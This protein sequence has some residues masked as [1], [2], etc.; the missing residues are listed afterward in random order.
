[1]G[2]FQFGLIGDFVLLTNHFDEADR[3]GEGCGGSFYDLRQPDYG[4]MFLNRDD[5]GIHG[6]AQYIFLR[7]R[8]SLLLLLLFL[9][10]FFLLFFLLFLLRFLF[11]GFEWRGVVVSLDGDDPFEDGFL[12]VGDHFGIFVVVVFI[13]GYGVVEFDFEWSCLI[14]FFCEFNGDFFL[15][16]RADEFVG[17]LH[18]DDCFLVGFDLGGGWGTLKT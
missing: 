13:G 9:F 6:F 8:F 17:E 12:G 11:L 18:G 7:A 15:G 3:L 10:L 14:G 16:V 1:V 5:A 2:R 4:G